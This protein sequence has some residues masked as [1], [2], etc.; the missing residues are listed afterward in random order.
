M[1]TNKQR[2]SWLI[3]YHDYKKKKNLHPTYHKPRFKDSKNPM[4][5]NKDQMY[6]T[7]INESLERVYVCTNTKT[8]SMT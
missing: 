5:Q 4:S 1:K 3:V 6:K 2:K 7:P 8:I